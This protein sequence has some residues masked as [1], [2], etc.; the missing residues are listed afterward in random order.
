MSSQYPKYY[1]LFHNY[2]LD[3]KLKYFEYGSYNYSKFFKDIRSN[4]ILERYNKIVK[5]E[6]GEKRTCNW[7]VF[8][9]FI[10]KEI[11][12]INDILGKNENKNILF[13][14]KFSKFG[15]NKFNTITNEESIKENKN[16][17]KLV[18]INEKMNITKNWL[19][20]KFNN[21]RYNA[22]ITLFYFVI[23]PFLKQI[24]DS[25]LV[26]LNELNELILKL[27]DDVNEKNY[28]NIIIYLQKNRFDS[29]NKKIDEI[30]NED[31]EDKNIDF[32]SSGYAA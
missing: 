25:S 26:K 10:N 11:I 9:N 15:I 21:C 12:R 7:V 22:Y 18:E 27:A 17:I 2:F 4:S 20:Q 13:E 6:L 31:D 28:F 3:T 24:K 8:L 1:N 14:S 29:N 32:T 16:L 30:I 5:T 19:V 23:S